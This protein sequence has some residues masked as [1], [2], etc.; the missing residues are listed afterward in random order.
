MVKIITVTDPMP[1]A[2]VPVL[3]GNEKFAAAINEALAAA[4]AD[5]TISELAIKYFGVDTT[6]PS[7]SEESETTEE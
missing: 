6:N 3:K 2:Y 7:G 4:Q 1:N 5:G